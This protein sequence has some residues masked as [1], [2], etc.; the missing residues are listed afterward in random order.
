MTL[1]LRGVFA[2][3]AV[4]VLAAQVARSG[5]EAVADHPADAAAAFAATFAATFAALGLRP[6]PPP[7]PGTLA[8]VAAGCGQ[9]V[10]LAW[11]D[12]NGLGQA[13]ARALL[14]LPGEPRFVYLGFV[15]ARAAPAPIAA[16]WATASLLHVLGLRAGDVPREVV[17]VMLPPACPQLAG[18][19]WS[20]LSPWR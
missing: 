9:P 14:T 4:L 8:G 12:F 10:S 17:L 15:G 18:L 6:V 3:L 16:R 1:V 7:V 5:A 19:D 11:V 2:A 13:A 20:R